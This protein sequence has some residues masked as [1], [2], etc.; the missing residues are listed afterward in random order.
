[1]KPK[2]SLAGG[3]FQVTRWTMFFEAQGADVAKSQQ[4]LSEFCTKY[5][6]PLY[7]FIRRQGFAPHDAEDL[8]QGFLAQF[9]GQE[10][11]RVAARARGRFRTFLLACLKNYLANQWKAQIRQKRGGGNVQ[12]TP[13]PDEDGAELPIEFA[14]HLT[15]E[16]Q[17]DKKWAGA[18][19]ESALKTLSL[20]MAD[21]GKA[22][23]FKKFQPFI[24]GEK[25]TGAYET[26]AKESGVSEGSLRV[27][28]HR[29]RQRYSEILRAEIM[30][31]VDSPEEANE[32]IRY[33]LRLFSRGNGPM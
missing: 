8:T 33:L 15:P 13:I 10:H 25:S 9:I 30:Q 21:A 6:Q 2:S 29:L 14:D 4:A 7:T 20:E 28:I 1:M 16:L 27:S 12:S 23:T 3:R 26:L 31:T 19:I 18:I 5:W 24:A 32:E 17:Y 22:E 11:Y